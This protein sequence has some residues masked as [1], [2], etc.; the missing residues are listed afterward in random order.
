[1]GA[2]LIIHIFIK[3]ARMSMFKNPLIKDITFDFLC[4]Y[5]YD[6]YR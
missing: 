6:E 2:L 3:N 4:F 1:M 5:I